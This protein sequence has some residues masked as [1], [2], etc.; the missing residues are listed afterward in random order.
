MKKRTAAAEHEIDHPVD[1]S[2][3]KDLPQGQQP[4]FAFHNKAPFVSIYKKESGQVCDYFS[5]DRE[6][7]YLAKQAQLVDC[8]LQW[9]KMEWG[10]KI[11]EKFE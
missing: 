4:L 2:H 9:H 6:S 8:C 10:R 1:Q 5:H 3:Y 11:L 7:G